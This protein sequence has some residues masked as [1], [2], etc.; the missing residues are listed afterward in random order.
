MPPLLIV[1]P[2]ENCNLKPWNLVKAGGTLWRKYGS[3]I[4]EYKKIVI[5]IPLYTSK[6]VYY[7]ERLA[8]NPSDFVINFSSFWTLLVHMYNMFWTLLTF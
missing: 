8:E 1:A 3:Q 4:I 7:M 5:L 2:Q 6:I